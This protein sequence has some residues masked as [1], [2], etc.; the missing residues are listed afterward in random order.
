M[1]FYHVLSM[2]LPI[3]TSDTIQCNSMRC[4]LLHIGVIPC[5][6]TPC[7]TFILQY[8]TECLCQRICTSGEGKS[9]EAGSVELEEPLEV[10]LRSSK[11]QHDLMRRIARTQART[12]TSQTTKPP[13]N[14]HESPKRK[15]SEN[16]SRSREKPRKQRTYPRWSGNILRYYEKATNS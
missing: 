6:V 14:H 8:F 2:C 7:Y 11:V 10:T 1:Y 5:V 16:L 9:V 15:K 13:P 4:I 3:S 12:Q